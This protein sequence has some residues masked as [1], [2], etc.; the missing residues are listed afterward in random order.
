MCI[1]DS[2]SS[3]WVLRL[4][5]GTSES[6]QKMLDALETLWPY[7]NEWTICTDY[8]IEILGNRHQY[9]KEKWEEKIH[10]VL[11]EAG[12]IIPLDVYAQRGGKQGNHTEHLGYILAEMQFLQRAY[13]NSEW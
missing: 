10:A 6:K 12:L 11:N 5:D 3:E 7:I 13:P 2:W 1:R 4:G 8:E 9:I